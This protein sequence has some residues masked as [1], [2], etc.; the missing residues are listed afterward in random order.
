M[1]IKV[2]T[3]IEV[4]DCVFVCVRAGARARVQACVR[5]PPICNDT[6]SCVTE[7]ETD[8]EC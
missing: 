1:P 5:D 7:K 6:I 4:Q 3:K 2:L 8:V